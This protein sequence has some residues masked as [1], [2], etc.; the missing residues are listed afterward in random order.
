LKAK[1][2]KTQAA[3]LHA[4]IVD[5]E[6]QA[7]GAV[8]GAGWA[9]RLRR[10][11]ENDAPGAAAA[12]AAATEAPAAQVKEAVA[13]AT[14][15]CIYGESLVAIDATRIQMSNVAPP[16]ALRALLRS[17]TTRAAWA[18]RSTAGR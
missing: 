8:S 6:H 18:R 17:A 10:E 7:R 11:E 9:G 14:D 12:S 13:I 3:V 4:R 1:I 2:T 15:A 16:E 5:K